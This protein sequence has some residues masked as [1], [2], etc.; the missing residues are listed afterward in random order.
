MTSPLLL[1]AEREFRTYVATVSFWLSLAMAPLGATGVLL[2]SAHQ[3]PAMMVTIEAQDRLVVQSATR[4]LNEAGHLEG[5]SF[6]FGQSGAR[7]TILSRQPQF[8]DVAFS[9]DF[10]LSPLGRAM[11][12]HM[13]ER[14]AARRSLGKAPLVVREKPDIAAVS[15]RVALSRL[16]VMS[17]LWL[18]LTGSLGMLLQAVVRERANRALESLL[19]CVRP[20][21]IVVGK[22]LGVG[23]VSLLVLAGWGTTAF[24]LSRFAGQSSPLAG[25]LAEF[26]NPAILVRDGVIYVCAFAFYGTTAVMFGALARDGA[27]AQNVARP[28]FVLLLAGFFVALGSAGAAAWWPWLIYIPP[29][30]PFLLLVKS[31]GCV[32]ETTQILLLLAQLLLALVMSWW[33]ARLLTIAPGANHI[34]SWKYVRTPQAV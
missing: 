33:T 6:M 22:I 10:P 2:F 19:A 26:S 17:I 13:I 9:G 8:L 5:R 23:S 28:M 20:W 14:D 31:P 16:A 1:I 27:S 24:L 32:A 21:Q 34:S 25:L 18:L 29:F 7:V 12:G 15:D 11:V 30:T 3:Q 4:A